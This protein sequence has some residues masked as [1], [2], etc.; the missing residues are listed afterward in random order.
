MNCVSVL[1]WWW[2]VQ[3]AGL[4]VVG[5]VS[6]YVGLVVCQF[7]GLV[8]VSK[9][10]WWWWVRCQYAGLVWCVLYLSSL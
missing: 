9:L 4:V 1:G 7:V 10:G 3:Y 2:R 8:G 5:E 6:R